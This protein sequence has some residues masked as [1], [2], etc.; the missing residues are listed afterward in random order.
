MHRAELVDFEARALVHNSTDRFFPRRSFFIIVE[1]STSSIL[2]T[3]SG[4]KPVTISS[5][6]FQ[7]N[8]RTCEDE[9]SK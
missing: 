8:M 2:G 1:E 7:S 4:N 9:H 3:F 5:D 6:N